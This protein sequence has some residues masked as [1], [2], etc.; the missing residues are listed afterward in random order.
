MLW[1]SKVNAFGGLGALLLGCRSNANT[2]NEEVWPS[3]W[4]QLRDWLQLC[5]WFQLRDLFQL[6][7]WLQLRDTSRPYIW[8]NYMWFQ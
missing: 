8:G 3:E 2:N 6:C 4:F 1:G 7:G 5:E